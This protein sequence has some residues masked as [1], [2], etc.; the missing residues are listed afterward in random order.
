MTDKRDDN[1]SVLVVEKK[2]PYMLKISSLE[3]LRGQ[4]KW[5]K[6]LEKCSESYFKCFKDPG[7]E[8]KQETDPRN[9]FHTPASTPTR[10]RTIEL[11][12]QQESTFE[13]YNFQFQFDWPVGARKT[14]QGYVVS[15][16]PPDIQ[17]WK[18]Q[19]CPNCLEYGSYSCNCCV[20]KSQG[21]VLALHLRGSIDS[22]HVLNAFLSG[23][24]A[25][26]IFKKLTPTR[27][28][29]LVNDGESY[30]FEVLKFIPEVITFSS[31]GFLII[32]I[33][34]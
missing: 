30:S 26:H 4:F 20:G 32:D 1:Q 31:F 15:I 16:N 23:P 3:Q 5:D 14:V 13:E 8:S 18:V 17:K 27:L 33:N 34:L 28:L 11:K 2:A 21:Y 24:E 6:S 7:L 29:E 22:I 9:I 10:Q 19:I 12:V 25:D